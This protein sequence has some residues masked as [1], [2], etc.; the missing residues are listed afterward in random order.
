MERF[1]K[2]K[3]WQ[4]FMI[5]FG[6]PILLEI[7]IMPFLAAGNNPMAIMKVMPIIMIL[8]IGAFFGWFRSNETILRFHPTSL[9]NKLPLVRCEQTK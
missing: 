9:V 1:L 6:L 4:I 8:F 7:I 2:A 5:T 3:H